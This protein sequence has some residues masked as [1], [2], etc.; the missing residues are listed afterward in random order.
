MT[1]DKR[2]AVMLYKATLSVFKKWLVQGL[3]TQADY[4]VID[5]IVAEKYGLSSCSI[6][7]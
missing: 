7:R 4:D 5:T 2:T 6:Y 3:I 1:E